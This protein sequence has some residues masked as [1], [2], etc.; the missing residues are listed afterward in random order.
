MLRISLVMVSKSLYSKIGFCIYQAVAEQNFTINVK[1]IDVLQQFVRQLKNGVLL[2]YENTRREDADASVTCPKNALLY[3]LS[4]NQ[5]GLSALPM[6]GN[7]EFI[8]L[9][10]QS[11][12]RFPVQGIMPFNIIEP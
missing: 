1:L 9:L 3:I 5:E 10:A 8:T 4:N 12:N 7:V 2:V 6:E 11:M